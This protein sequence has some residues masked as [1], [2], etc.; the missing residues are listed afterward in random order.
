MLAYNMDVS[1]ASYA[2]VAATGAA[3]RRFPFYVTEAGYFDAGEEYFT[4]RDGRDEALF[5]LTHAGRGEI[6]WQGQTCSLTAGAAVVITCSAEHEYHT[7]PGGRWKFSWAHFSGSG[8][9]GY[10]SSLLSRLLPLPLR[11]TEAARSLLHTLYRLS[12]GPG[13]AEMAQCSHAISGILTEMM[14]SLSRGGPQGGMEALAEYI[15]LHCRDALSMADLAD[16]AHIS[17]SR[18]AHA[19]AGQMGMPPGQYLHMCRV[20]LAQRLLRETDMTVSAV[21]SEVGY[22]DSVSLIRHFRRVTGVTPGGYRQESIRMA[23]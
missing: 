11:D 21:A 7:S 4:R 2:R 15:R 5:I 20:N 10:R 9:E 18:L 6:T 13:L 17:P 14:V 22:G 8:L 16:R 3:A 12:E 19:F 1:G 23:R